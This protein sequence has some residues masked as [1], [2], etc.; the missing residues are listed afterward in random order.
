M[1]R[2][3]ILETSTMFAEVALADDSGIV[4]SEHLS[5]ARRHTRDLAPVLGEMLRRADWNPKSINLVIVDE[6]PGS[7]TGLRVGVVTAKLFAYTT[8]AALIA[9]D[10]MIALAAD[11]PAKFSS[12]S[13]IIDAQQG[14]VYAATLACGENG[15]EPAFLRATE[16]MPATEWASQLTPEQFVIGPALSRFA[17]LVPEGVTAAPPGRFNPSANALWKIGIK[18]FEAGQRDDIWKLEPRYLR[19][20]AAQEK[21]DQRLAN[22][23]GEKTSS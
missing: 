8:G 2:A 18:R 4:A 1:V 15:V 19:P 20:S 5:S 12:V 23:E 11:A 9:V 14:L 6:G 22:K 10:A 17:H 21:W 7:Y 16:V 13:P 3:L